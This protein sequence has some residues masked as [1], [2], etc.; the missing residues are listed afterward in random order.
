MIP[1]FLKWIERHHYLMLALIIAFATLTRFWRLEYPPVYYFDEV[2]HVV[3]AKLMAFGDSRAYEWWNPPPE[4]GTAIDYLHPPLAK[5][6]QAGSML[7]FGV[8]SF[9]W[10]V[11]SAVFGV[12]VIVL[13][14]LVTRRLNLPKSVALLAAFL[15]AS[16]GLLLT[17]SRITMNDIHVTFFYLLTVL[18]YL[19]WKEK[20]AFFS[21]L[22]V[23]VS[24]GLA[25]ATKWSGVFVIGLLFVDLIWGW[26]SQTAA[27]FQKKTIFSLLGLLTV[28]VPLVYLASY[29]QMWLQGKSWQHFTE[30]NQQIWWYQNNLEATH[31]YQSTPVQWIFA[32]RPVYA[33]TADAGEGFLQNIYFQ[34]NPLLLWIG[35]GAVLFSVGTLAASFL[36]WVRT[37]QTLVRVESVSFEKTRKQ[38]SKQLKQ[39]PKYN[40]EL[41]FLLLA[42]FSTWI[43]WLHSPRIMF[44][45]H[46]T[47]AIPFLCII[48]AL[49]LWLLRKRYAWLLPSVLVSIFFV[50]LLL[51]PNFTA[52]RVPADPW[53]SLFFA[54]PSWR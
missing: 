18:F 7:L 4:P 39:L 53:H 12:G 40:Q 33:Y 49:Q 30:L 50:F 36:V 17:M 38:I 26:L 1:K 8:T 21:A 52:L 51:Y 3:T 24:A 11:S 48:L 42:Y 45:Y 29:G 10:R 32:M 28:V 44:F 31:P 13:T 20:P 37:G 19:R 2:Y 34:A 35:I 14:Y 47:P 16:D 15:A 27:R 5:L 46:Y 43:V 22:W 25:V 6:I 54:F 9:G 23:A 41:L